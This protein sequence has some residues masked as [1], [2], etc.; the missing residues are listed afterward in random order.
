MSSQLMLLEPR[1]A[2]NE[3]DSVGEPDSLLSR[4]DAAI[5]QVE[6]RFGEY[7]TFEPLLVDRRA[8]I[9]ESIA[10]LTALPCLLRSRQSSSSQSE[11]IAESDMQEEANRAMSRSTFV[12]AAI[13]IRPF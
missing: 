1:K 10:T 9:A 13:E 7:V 5:F 3:K 4:A 2:V 12:L 8:A 11:V 6:V